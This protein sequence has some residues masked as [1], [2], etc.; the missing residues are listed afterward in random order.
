MG[1]LVTASSIRKSSIQHHHLQWRNTSL[2]PS[3]EICNQLLFPR[4]MLHL[5]TL[6]RS[7][8]GKN[9]VKKLRR[10]G[11]E[12][13]MKKEELKRDFTDE[14][15]SR[16]DFVSGNNI[17][18]ELTNDNVVTKSALPSPSRRGVLQACVVTSGLMF[19]IGL[20]IRQGSHLVVKEGWPIYDCFTLVSFDFETW[21]LELIAGLVILISSARFLL[22]KTWPKFA[23]SSEASNQMVLSQLEPLDYILVAC[24]PGLSEELLFRGALMPLFGLDWKSVLVV[25][26]MFGVLHLGSGRKYSFAIWATFVGLA[27]GYAAI[28]SSS[29][30]VPMTSHALN[31][32]VGAIL[33]RYI[34]DIS[35]QGLE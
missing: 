19:A 32:L 33:W 27:Y 2:L 3:C 24:L 4:K 5:H 12:G 11:K 25:A 16:G 35:E 23:E 22:L 10:D 7:F 13:K 34:S 14:S 15:S 30:I 6:V 9:S 18:V 31:N 29:I 17:G 26:A 8:A 1:T 28:I 21:H 20:L